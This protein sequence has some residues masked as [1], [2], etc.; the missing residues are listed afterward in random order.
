IQAEQIIK[1]KRQLNEILGRHCSK[2]PEQIHKDAERDRYFTAAEAKEY[3]LVDEV[4][5]HPPKEGPN[6]GH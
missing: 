2:S 4:L 6:L 3:G 1:S 5:A